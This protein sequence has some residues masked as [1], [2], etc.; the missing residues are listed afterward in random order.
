MLGH[1]IAVYIH[2][3]DWWLY[4]PQNFPAILLHTIRVDVTSSHVCKM[5]NQ[6]WAKTPQC[7]FVSLVWIEKNKINFVCLFGVFAD[8]SL[9]QWAR[10][11]TMKSSFQSNP[12]PTIL[13]GFRTTR[14]SDSSYDNAL[15]CQRWR[16]ANFLIR[17]LFF[18]CQTR[19]SNPGHLYRYPCLWPLWYRSLKSVN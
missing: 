15:P 5:T 2:L 17:F 11:K 18:F 14:L 3:R 13:G 6:A 8:V 10:L 19:D 7:F 16:R 1:T 9:H 12:G 4:K